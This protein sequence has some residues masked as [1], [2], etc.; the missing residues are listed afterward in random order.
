M[1]KGINIFLGDEFVISSMAYKDSGFQQIF[2]GWGPCK[3]TVET[4]DTFKIGAKLC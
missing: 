2:I 4:N 3:S 1:L